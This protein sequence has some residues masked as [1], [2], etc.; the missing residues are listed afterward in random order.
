MAYPNHE[1][2]YFEVALEEESVILT[3]VPVN[4]EII[5]DHQKEPGVSST[6][7]VKVELL[8]TNDEVHPPETNE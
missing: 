4:E 3:L 8:S 5:E 1:K 6:S 7:E 2:N